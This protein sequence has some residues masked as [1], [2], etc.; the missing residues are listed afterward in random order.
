[1]NKQIT[2]LYLIRAYVEKHGSLP[3]SHALAL[4][5][6]LERVAKAQ[7]KPFMF[8]IQDEEGRAY[9]D[10]HCVSPDPSSLEPPEGCRV[11]ATYAA[12]PLDALS[13]P[14]GVM[15]AYANI[16]AVRG[17]DSTTPDEL[18]AAIRYLAVEAEAAISELLK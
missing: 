18:A 6:A 13:L 11:V 5:G 14:R 9:M 10:E 16:I 12:P 8:A 2:N 15:S 17:R 7:E 3:K 1:M 4:I